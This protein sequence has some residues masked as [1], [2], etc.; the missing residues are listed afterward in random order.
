MHFRY[1]F[2]LLLGV[3][4]W[5]TAAHGQVEPDSLL[6]QLLESTADE[7]AE[8]TDYAELVE[9]LA[10]YRRHPID[11]N[12]TDGTELQE[13][14]FVPLA[15]IDRLLEHRERS[16][17]FV[18]VLELQALAGADP[19]LLRLLWPYVTV[20]PPSPMAGVGQRRLADES[21]Q[22]L[23]IRYSR[24]L[25]LRQGYTIT[26]TTRS[27]FLGS[28]Y[29]LQVRYRYR[30]GRRLQLTLNLEKDAGEAFFRGTQ[31]YGFDF[32]SGS[33]YW[34]GDGRVAA[35]VVG[36]FTLQ[37]GQGLVTWGSLAFGKGA[38]VQ[39]L[40]RM[41][42][43]I[44]S[45]TSVN[46]TAFLRGA[47]A[48]LRFGPLAVTPYVSWRRLDG[49][50]EKSADG[51]R[52]VR[53]FSQSGLHRTPSEVA[54]KHA[55][56]QR[57]YGLD[58][59]YVRRRLRAGTV[60][61]YTRYDIPVHPAD[62]L[63]NRFS[64]HGSDLWNASLYYRYGLWGVQFFGEAA[65]RRDAPAV[66]S[67]LLAPLHPQLSIAVHFRHY[68]PGYYAP[69][70]MPLT[71]GST[72]A[73]ETGCYAG[74][75]YQRARTLEWIGYA[76]VFR[77]PWL[78]YRVD[79]PSHGADLLTQLTIQRYRRASVSLRYRY[80]QRAENNSAE[81]SRHAVVTVTRQQVRLHGQYVLNPSWTLRFR[82]EYVTY[83]KEGQVAEH[84]WMTYTE[85]VWRPVAGRVSGNF[86][87][88]WFGT[89]GYETRV[90][91]Y[92]PAGMY[93][94]AFLAYHQRGIRAYAN[95][96]YRFGRRVDSW[97]RYTLFVYR[98]EEEI[99]SGLDA[100]SGNRRSDISVQF[101]F[102]F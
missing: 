81:A 58:V 25:E 18:S 6:E 96:R 22:E 89:P 70:A 21:E 33:L 61:Q 42:G 83:R 44:R 80:R 30:Y 40:V 57:L 67:G 95:V 8:D 90:Y 101:R 14:V 26:D 16:G 84:G 93:G 88:A 19:V 23:A 37:V 10:Y 79:G 15:F 20:H 59:Q 73:N 92:E 74:L 17:A 87:L 66:V 99:G 86:R 12:R 38:T 98:G 53:T 55:I 7:R 2:L 78:R 13:L 24:T 68:S 94:G 100:I 51:A 49:T 50:I 47:A 82:S 31:R 56:G 62:L 35:L 4:A 65:Y 43:G 54:G 32:C 76:D 48:T 41:A 77:F 71:E 72:P 39:S 5:A 3:Q 60:A 69:Y 97:L 91:A 102:R 63:R 34:Q 52:M 29:Q 46:E 85:A 11:L 9:R 36:D 45:H 28:P 75:V 27:R 1:G 64:F